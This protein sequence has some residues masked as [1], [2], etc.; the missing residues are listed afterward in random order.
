MKLFFSSTRDKLPLDPQPDF[1]DHADSWD[2]SWLWVVHPGLDPETF[3][4]ENEKDI[5]ACV[6]RGGALLFISGSI[7]CG[8]SEAKAQQIETEKKG[9]LHF[10]RSA[11]SDSSPNSKPSP[12]VAR[13][14]RF[15]KLME[16]LQP[17][18][19]V[20]WPEVEASKWPENL[21][22]VYLMMKALET[23]PDDEPAIRNA[24]ELM[25]SAWKSQ[26]WLRAWKE[27]HEELK[28]S[29]LSWTAA[30][31]PVAEGESG[32]PDSSKL[33]A[34]TAVIRRAFIG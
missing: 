25:D 30:G 15:L 24:W 9:R 10:L 26:V 17:Y 23:C 31:L 22:A 20:P 8:L 6:D 2:G 14:L 28:M 21:L 7:R 19:A 16:D 33:P 29:G 18:E 5:K 12:V 13:I 32:I 4:E 3:L 27:Y 11:C 1:S 34:A